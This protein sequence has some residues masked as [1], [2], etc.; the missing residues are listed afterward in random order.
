MKEDTKH[1]NLRFFFNYWTKNKKWIFENF[2]IGLTF[3]LRNTKY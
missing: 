2:G 1:N 3:Y